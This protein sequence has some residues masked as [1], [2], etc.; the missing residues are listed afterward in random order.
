MKN[1]IIVVIIIAAGYFFLQKFKKT[2]VGTFEL[3]ART[4]VEAICAGLLSNEP[5]AEQDAVAF[6]RFGKKATITEADDA[7]FRRFLKDGGLPMKA[8]SCTVGKIELV[9]ADSS[10]RSA[11][12][13]VSVNGG[14]K[15]MVVRD[16]QD[17]DWN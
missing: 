16:R 4:R 1:L 12:V 14:K 10:S 11:K 2:D 13:E 3:H 17:V 9:N 7:A 15:T 6:W 8:N 5:F